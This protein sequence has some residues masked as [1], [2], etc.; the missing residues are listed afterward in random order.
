MRH[1]KGQIASFWMIFALRKSAELLAARL[2]NSPCVAFNYNEGNKSGHD[3]VQ[4]R[5]KN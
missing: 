3:P 5:F 2:L 1:K 4:T